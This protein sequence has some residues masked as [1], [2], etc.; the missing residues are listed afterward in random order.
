MIHHEQKL[1]PPTIPTTNNTAADNTCHLTV[2][3]GNSESKSYSGSTSRRRAISDLTV[4]TETENERDKRDSNDD[5]M[6]RAQTAPVNKHEKSLTSLIAGELVMVN[7][8]SMCSMQ[9]VS[10]DSYDDHTEQGSPV[11]EQSPSVS[12]T[13]FGI[14]TNSPKET[15]LGIGK[16]SQLKTHSIPVIHQLDSVSQC[17]VNS[18]SHSSDMGVGHNKNST[19]IVKEVNVETLVDESHHDG[20]HENCHGIDETENAKDTNHSAEHSRDSEHGQGT[21]RKTKS[22]ESTNGHNDGQHG[23]RDNAVDANSHTFDVRAQRLKE[24]QKLFFDDS[25]DGKAR[26]RSKRRQN[27]KNQDLKDKLKR[28]QSVADLHSHSPSEE[29]RRSGVKNAEP[30]LGRAQTCP[31]RSSTSVVRDELEMQYKD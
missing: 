25:K 17:S 31:T 18:Y 21:D 20:H 26:S 7:T 14:G 9:T 23:Q 15:P 10:V 29:K 1:K 11:R 19:F 8:K 6:D 27:S 22:M 13:P 2:N 30:N 5:R 16:V 24:I 3:G 12:G 4:I 28:H